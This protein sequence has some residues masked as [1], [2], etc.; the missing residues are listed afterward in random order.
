MK[1]KLNHFPR[2]LLAVQTLAVVAMA[3]NPLT[4]AA[5]FA[6]D[7]N[8]TSNTVTKNGATTTFADEG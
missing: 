5:S 2:K 3:W 6:A 8:S 1:K 4:T 7:A